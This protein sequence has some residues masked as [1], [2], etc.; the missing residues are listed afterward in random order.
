ML[1]Q[2]EVTFS[3]NE[4]L[5][6]DEDGGFEGSEGREGFEGNIFNESSGD[7]SG[8][9]TRR[10]LFQKPTSETEELELTEQKADR[11]RA[12]DDKPVIDNVYNVP[13]ETL[14]DWL[15]GDVEEKE[16]KFLVRFLT[17]RLRFKNVTFGKWVID[18]DK[19]EKRQFRYLFDLK[20]TQGQKDSLVI[21]YQKYIEKDV[22]G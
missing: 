13:I 21:N 10:A 7:E 8:G 6:S 4:S 22:K 15:F 18:E 12:Q 1:S 11:I 3:D 19:V 2:T 5:F 20:Q 9:K 14:V 16:D 17:Q